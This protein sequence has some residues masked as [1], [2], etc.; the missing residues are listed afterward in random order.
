MP[1]MTGARFIAETFKEYGVTHV[2]FVPAILSKAMAEMENLGMHRVLVH[3][4][5]AAAYM[6]DGYARSSHRPG[7]CMAQSVGAA[8][9]AAGLQDAYLGLSSV[10]AITGHKPSLQR[11]RHSY[12]E[13][14]HAPL[15][16]PVTKFNAVV[17][18]VDQLPFFL[19]QAFRETTS[20]A[21]G[22]VHLD[23]QGYQGEVVTEAETDLEVIVEEQF[24]CYP[25][26]RMEPEPKRIRETVKLFFT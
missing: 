1:K 10:I 22:P 19:R 20:G 6:A 11:Y 5:K 12:Q 7:I 24:S 16:R 18:T 8:N 4:E 13:I 26:F 14:E 15:F 3:S 17:D 21:P 9:L 25:A 2:F 23:L